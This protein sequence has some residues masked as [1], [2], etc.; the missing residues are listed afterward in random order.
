[1]A[2]EENRPVGLSHAVE[3]MRR[4]FPSD[5]GNPRENSLAT[6]A[7]EDEHLQQRLE[8]VPKNRASNALQLG[9][10][11]RV[12]QGPPK[13]PF[14]SLAL[15]QRYDVGNSPQ[16]AAEDT[17]RVP[18]QPGKECERDFGTDYL[19]TA[20]SRLVGPADPL[21]GREVARIGSEGRVDHDV[22]PYTPVPMPTRFS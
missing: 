14:R 10:A 2:G 12:T 17:R 22:L 19:E 18:R 1:M 3:D 5:E 8:E 7:A 6:P 9:R 16:D 4:A 21:A 20:A 11:E 13:V 15:A